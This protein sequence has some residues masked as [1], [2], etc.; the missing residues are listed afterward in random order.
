MTSS[1]STWRAQAATARTAP[2][3]WGWRRRC[4]PA[5]RKAGPSAC[6][7]RARMRWP[8]R[9]SAPRRP[10]TSKPISTRKAKSSAGGTTSGATAT[11]RGP[12]VPRRRRCTRPGSSPSR[13]RAW[14]PSIRRWR[15]AAGRSAMPRR[16]TIF[17]PG[18]LPT[19][20]CSPCRSAA[21]RCG[22]S[23]HLPTCSPS[24]RSWTSWRP[25]AARTRWPSA[26]AI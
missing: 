23:G 7:G 25:S 22:R 17:L 3:M 26:C 18:R 2:T 13:S 15:A 19:T 6:C 4:W 24:S 12:A 8:G 1:S 16:P 21:R 11:C 20:A 9:R 10:S 14:W 5:R